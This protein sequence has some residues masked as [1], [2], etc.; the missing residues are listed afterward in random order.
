ME[1]PVTVDG[2]VYQAGHTR[3]YVKVGL[4]TE[5][6]MSNRLVNVEIENHLQ[7]LR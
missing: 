3:E 2:E 1:E 5:E 4:K 6:N 7:I